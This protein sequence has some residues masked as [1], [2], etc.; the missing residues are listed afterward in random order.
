MVVVS[1]SSKV[2]SALILE[3]GPTVEGRKKRCQLHWFP[4]VGSKVLI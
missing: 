3:L 2:R 1:K 4:N